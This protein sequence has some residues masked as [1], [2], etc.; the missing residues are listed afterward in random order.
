[1]LDEIIKK[2]DVLV[3]ALP[4]IREFKKK[5][6]VI[7]Y[8]GRALLNKQVKKNILSDIVFMATV[9]IKPVLIH[10]G[11]YSITEQIK[12]KGESIR[13]NAGKRVT[14]RKG[15]KIV[16]D[17]LKSI[18]ESLV[19]DLVSLGAKAITI[20]SK[21]E[22]IIRVKPESKELGFVG[23]IIDLDVDYIKTNFKKGYIPVIMPVGIGPKNKLYNINAD[24]TACNIA[25]FLKA[26]KLMLLTDVKGILREKDDDSSLIS[27]LKANEVDALK[28]MGVISGGMIPKVNACIEALRNGVRKTH[29]VDGR[30]PHALLL[31]VFT[32]EGI[33]TEIVK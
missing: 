8:G 32:T 33:G 20:D 31:E 6:V 29:I 15:I 19:S 3:E 25:I 4:Y 5:I 1:M 21:K 18:N 7:K 10:G 12:K 2:A 17:V 22:D 16:Y 9:G 11:G 30:I 26:E 23:E 24:D 28:K 14:D 27:T 13:F